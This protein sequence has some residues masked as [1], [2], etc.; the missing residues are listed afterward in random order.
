[1]R[2]ADRVVANAPLAVVASKR[3]MQESRDWP[4]E[5]MFARQQKIKEPIAASQDAKE[6]VRSFVKRRAPVWVGH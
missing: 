5:E 4:R 2:L 3:V 6:G 1:M